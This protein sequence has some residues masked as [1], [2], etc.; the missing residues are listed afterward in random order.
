[1]KIED[2]EDFCLKVIDAYIK[3]IEDYEEKIDCK[4]IKVRTHAKSRIF[5]YYQRKRDII[6]N[7][8]MEKTAVSLDRHKVAACMMYAVLRSR[9]LRV[10]EFIPHGTKRHL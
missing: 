2:F 8:Y 9:V 10:N 6:K 4:C 5:K 1:M 7:N 3:D